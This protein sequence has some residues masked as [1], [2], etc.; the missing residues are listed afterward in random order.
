MSTIYKTPLPEFTDKKPK[1]KLLNVYPVSELE[2]RL[3]KIRFRGAYDSSGNNIEPYKDISFTLETIYPPETAAS[4]PQVTIGYAKTPLY[5]SQPYLYDVQTQI[6]QTLYEFLETE[7]LDLFNL[8]G[9][10]E[11]EWEGRGIYHVMPPIVERHSYSL[12]GG[13]LDLDKMSDRF[14]GHYV[15]DAKGNMHHLSEEVLNDFYIDDISRLPNLHIFNPNIEIVNYGISMTGD[16]KVNII[17]DGSHRIDYALEY[18]QR[19]IRTIVVE[20]RNKPLIP[21]YALP[22]PFRPSIRLSS[23]RSVG[24]Y[25]TLARDKVHLFNSYISHVLHYD[26]EGAGLNISSLRLNKEIY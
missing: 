16:W 12:N 6:I 10:I 20:G 22:V 7:G 15:R 17:C 13:F 9:I 4:L 26:W 8:E 24:I 23:K 18:M 25:P 5:T 19:P 11:Y 14:E 1:L 2:G 21:Y 3:S